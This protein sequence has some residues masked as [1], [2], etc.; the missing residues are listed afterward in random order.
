MLCREV[1][2]RRPEG[3]TQALQADTAISAANWGEVALEPSPKIP[4][5]TPN[6][7]VLGTSVTASPARTEALKRT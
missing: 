3:F 2:G 4:S 5:L 7:H 1:I 6:S